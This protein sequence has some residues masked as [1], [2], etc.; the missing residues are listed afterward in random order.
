MSMR[1]QLIH[2]K[3]GYDDDEEEEKPATKARS[4]ANAKLSVP[5]N[6][7]KSGGSHETVCAGRGSVSLCDT[8]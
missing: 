3:D 5:G 2:R 6:K 1:T 8:K 4:S 7:T